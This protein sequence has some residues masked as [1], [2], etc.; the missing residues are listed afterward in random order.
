MV[1]IET[2][3]MY[4]ICCAHVNF[5]YIKMLCLF[6]TVTNK[7]EEH[8]IFNLRDIKQN[9]NNQEQLAKEEL[10]LIRI[11]LCALDGLKRFGKLEDIN[12]AGIIKSYVIFLIDNTTTLEQEEIYFAR[13]FLSPNEMYENFIISIIPDDIEQSIKY[14]RMQANNELMK[15]IIIG[16]WVLRNSSFSRTKYDPKIRYYA[17]SLRSHI[18]L[19]QHGLIIYQEGYGWKGGDNEDLIFFPCFMDVL[20]KFL[21]NY[22]L[23]FSGKGHKGYI[24]INYNN[25]KTI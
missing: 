15:N 4:S 5:E 1:I 3:D 23:K 9:P 22:N 11:R 24:K 20:E 14:E 19:I 13:C 21:I 7:L 18:D 25:I 2:D 8:N 10:E 17:I 12:Y 6:N 16:K